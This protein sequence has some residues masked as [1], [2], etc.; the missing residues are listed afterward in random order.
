ME[1]CASHEEALSFYLQCSS[2]LPRHQVEY[3]PRVKQEG[4]LLIVFD[5]ISLNSFWG[6]FAGVSSSSPSEYTPK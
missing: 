1:L 2:L 4:T 3:D 5:A 6:N